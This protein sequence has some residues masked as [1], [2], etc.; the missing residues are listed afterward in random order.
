MMNNGEMFGI[1]RLGKVI[2]SRHP[3]LGCRVGII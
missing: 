2:S 1:G 3:F